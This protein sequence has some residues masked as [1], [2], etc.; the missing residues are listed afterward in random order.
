MAAVALRLA[1]LFAGLSRALS[2]TPEGYHAYGTVQGP[3]LWLRAI[4]EGRFSLQT[5][6]KLR[7]LCTYS[8]PSLSLDP[9]TR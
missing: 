9:P 7:G 3:T 5:T 6:G 1:S 2:P 8:G 4:G